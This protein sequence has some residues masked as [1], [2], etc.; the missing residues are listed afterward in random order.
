MI[1]TAS[2]TSDTMPTTCDGK[3]LWNG[4][5]NPVKLVVTVVARNSAVQ[6]LS[7]FAAISPNTTT[8][9]EPIPTRLNTTC[10][11]VNVVILKPPFWFST[12]CKKCEQIQ[13]VH[14]AAVNMLVGAQARH[15]LTFQDET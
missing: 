13:K 14:L 7:C 2:T 9:P 5:K 1:A 12:N 6:R 8:N 3:S 15:F 10:T 11:K 4:N